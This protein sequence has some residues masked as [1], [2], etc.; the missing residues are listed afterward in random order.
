M[1]KL[2]LLCMAL[3]VGI[4]LMAQT[5][6]RVVPTGGSADA[7]GSSWGNAVTLDRAIA[8]IQGL[9][10]KT[11]N[12]V[13]LKGGT[14]N[15]A[16]VLNIQ[17]VNLYGGFKGDE[18][19]FASRNWNANQTIIDGTS[20]ANALMGLPSTVSS[21]NVIDGLIFQ[22]SRN[23]AFG[24]ALSLLGSASTTAVDNV[25]RVSNCIF[26]NNVAVG[27]AIF[28]KWVTPTIDNCLFVNNESV[29]V[30]ANGC[31]F[32]IFC[33]INIINCTMAF[34]KGTNGIAYGSAGSTVKIYNSIMYGNSCTSTFIGNTATATSGY[35]CGADFTAFGKSPSVLSE[36]TGSLLLSAS[37]FVAGSGFAGLASGTNTFDMIANA[38]YRLATGSAC[39]NA[40]SATGLTIPTNDL[41]STAR[42]LGTSVDMGAYEYSGTTGFNTI[43]TGTS[44]NARANNGILTVSGVSKGNSIKIYNVS[45]QLMAQKASENITSFTL[46]GKG[47]ALVVV[48]KEVLKV[49]Y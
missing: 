48:G 1:K 18:T 40:G 2:L 12:Q 32:Q 21:Q 17:N 10:D 5:V 13:W 6:V 30:P 16:S 22:N 19:D 8:I 37:P 34:N 4:T 25:I 7:D 26:R 33:T 3:T 45:G 39:I 23:S 11:G 27:A 41:N 36:A 47:I 20:T 46:S 31:V 24:G 42:T 43:Q 9:T 44:F 28:A 14:Y 38:D 35:N 15:V 49:N 29:A